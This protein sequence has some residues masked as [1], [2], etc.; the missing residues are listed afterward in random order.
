MAKKLKFKKKRWRRKKG[1]QVSLGKVV[2]PQKGCFPAPAECSHL[3][4]C[5]VLSQDCRLLILLVS[6]LNQ[7]PQAAPVFFTPPCTPLPV[8]LTS[9]WKSSS[10]KPQGWLAALTT[11]ATPLLSH[12][13][14]GS[15]CSQQPFL[16]ACFL[17]FS[18]HFIPN[19]IPLNL[20]LA[21]F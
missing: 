12:Q 1:L 11:S 13:P 8:Q 2:S 6:D 3:A 17:L 4:A 14:Q 7:M 20:W 16:F 19:Y 18:F 9:G 10:L 21:S 5:A 15:Q